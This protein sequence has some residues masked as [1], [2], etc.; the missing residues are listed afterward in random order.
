MAR[1]Y[2]DIM[3]STQ[4]KFIALSVCREQMNCFKSNKDSNHESVMLISKKNCKVEKPL[5]IH[6]YVIIWIH[7]E[8]KWSFK[9]KKQHILMILILRLENNDI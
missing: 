2:N 9:K 3:D 7:H 8:S 4:T 6:T 1:Y 5:C